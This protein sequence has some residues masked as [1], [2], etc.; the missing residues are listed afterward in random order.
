MSVD[1]I[2]D[3]T[4]I[5]VTTYNPDPNSFIN[6]VASYLDQV[7]LIVVCD[8]STDAVKACDIENL[9]QSYESLVYFPMSG[10]QGIAAAQNSAIKVAQMRGFEYFLEMD[11]DSKLPDNYVIRIVSSFHR[12]ER[13]GI[14]VGG[15]G[16][17]AVNE[18]DGRA[19]HGR[20]KIGGTVR[21]DKT[22][23]SGFF[24]SSRAYQVIGPKDERLFI[25]F[26]DWDWCWRA[27]S[28]SLNI[29]VDGNLRI[30]HELGSGHTKVA[31]WYVGI[32]API[33]HYYQYRN[34][35]YLFFRPY[36]PVGW[37]VRRSII[38][39]FKFLYYSFFAPRSGE[40]R[41]YIYSGFIGFF[42]GE[43]GKF[44]RHG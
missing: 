18:K 40:R 6:N 29:F 5:L 16:P 25:D 24:Y 15:V 8:N 42:K 44:S 37:K 31:F 11:Q 4:A 38:Y 41:R 13:S 20:G 7:K 36:V 17:I 34:A 26:V 43:T 14:A 19:Y 28:L 30:E 22:L 3:K 32:P 27:S 39:L 9:C 23:S 10:N 21:V 35:M 1:Y 12:L 33:R 2:L